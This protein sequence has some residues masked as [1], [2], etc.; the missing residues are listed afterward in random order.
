MQVCVYVWEYVSVYVYVSLW[1][2]EHVDHNEND[3]V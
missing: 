1:V 2:C 3:C